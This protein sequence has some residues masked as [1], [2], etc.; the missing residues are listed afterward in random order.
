MI[1]NF[2]ADILTFFGKDITD[3][4]YPELRRERELHIWFSVRMMKLADAV[5]YDVSQREH[6]KEDFKPLIQALDE[7]YDRGELT[8]GEYFNQKGVYTKKLLALE[9]TEHKAQ[10][11]RMAQF[12]HR[13][14]MNLLDERLATLPKPRRKKRK[15]RA[16]IYRKNNFKRYT[17]DQRKWEKY[18][19]MRKSFLKWQQHQERQSLGELWNKEAFI[20]I[21]ASRGYVSELMIQ[22][23]ISMQTDSTMTQSRYMLDNGCFTW[24]QIMLIG[25]ALQL[26]PTEFAEC[27]MSG[28]FKEIGNGLYQATYDKIPAEAIVS[29]PIFESPDDKSEDS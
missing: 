15:P 28:Y 29:E 17:S 3:M 10:F 8:Q 22:Q 18:R 1:R 21:C 16:S 2:D 6:I 27:F 19:D 4:T 20:S 26:T 14:Y 9:R 13:A 23:L 25:A 7:A 5:E 12:Q 24:L 11:A